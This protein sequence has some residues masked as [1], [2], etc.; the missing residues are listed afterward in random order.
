M[1][2]QLAAEIWNS[3][4]ES[5]SYD[6]REELASN[7]VGIM[8]DHGCDLDDISHELRTDED[9]QKAVNYYRDE[10]ESED[11]DEDYDYYQDDDEDY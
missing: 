5:V 8:I 6:E 11:N 3:V 1:S 9:I 7:V 2:I 4:R 10:V